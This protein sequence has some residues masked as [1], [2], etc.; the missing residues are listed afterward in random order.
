M[1][2]VTHLFTYVYL[3]NNFVQITNTSNNVSVQLQ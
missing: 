3:D 1:Q 2:G